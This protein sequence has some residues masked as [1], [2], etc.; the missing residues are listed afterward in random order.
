MDKSTDIVRAIS[1]ISY[2]YKH[3]SCGQCTPCREGTGW[4][5]RM[6]ERLREGDADVRE[7]DTPARRHQAGRGPHHLRAGRRRRLADP[8]PDQALPPRARAADRR[9]RR[10]Q[11]AGGGGMKLALLIAACLFAL[12]RGRGLRR[13]PGRRHAISRSS[14]N[15]TTRATR[16][17]RSSAAIFARRD[18]ERAVA[19]LQSCVAACRS[20]IC[21]ARSTLARCRCAAAIHVHRYSAL[22]PILRDAIVL[23]PLEPMPYALPIRNPQPP[24]APSTLTAIPAIT[25]SL[26]NSDRITKRTQSPHSST[27]AP[28]AIARA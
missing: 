1:R 26:D 17:E 20:A 25:S 28:P 6:M 14:T 23:A 16:H 8:G 24:I 10:A 27:L 9:A 11:H 3:E 15:N 21:V 18:P 2:F 7:I 5:W 4:M 13:N 19:M 12:T 22:I